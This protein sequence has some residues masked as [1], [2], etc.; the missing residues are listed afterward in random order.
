[1]PTRHL[2]G[3]QILELRLP[4]QQ[5]VFEVQQQ[6]SDWF[7]KQAAPV[8]E[9]LFDRLAPGDEVV[10]LDKL[11]IDLGVIDPQRLFTSAFLEVFEEKMEVT[12]K[13]ALA[14][15]PRMGL[16]QSHFEQWVGFLEKGRMPWFA[17]QANSAK[18]G[19]QDSRLEALKN[20]D[21][22]LDK[23][24]NDLADL[25]LQSGVSPAA[26][27]AQIAQTPN[28]KA[29]WTYG[30]IKFLSKKAKAVITQKR[31][32]AKQKGVQLKTKKPKSLAAISPQ[33]EVLAAGIADLGQQ[34]STKAQ[35]LTFLETGRMPEPEPSS[36]LALHRNVLDTLGLDS[37]AVEQLRNLLLR[38][39]IAFDRL[40]LQHDGLF[41]EKVLVLYTGHDQTGIRQGMEEI[42]AILMKKLPVA[43]SNARQLEVFCWRAVLRRVVLQRHKMEP[44]SLLAYL[45]G[46]PEFAAVLP[47]LLKTA[48]KAKR[49]HPLLASIVSKVAPQKEEEIAVPA[50]PTFPMKQTDEELEAGIFVQNAGIVLLHPFLTTL[51]KKLGLTNE[52]KQFV[53]EE[54]RGRATALLHYLA[55]REAEAPEQDLT[56]P[57]LLSGIPL[58][59]PLDRYIQLTE[60]DMQEAEDLLETAIEMW[61]A[62]GKASPDGLREGFL[63][64]QGK[65]VRRERGWLLQVERNSLDIL[66]GKLPWGLG[67]VKLPWMTEM[68]MVEWG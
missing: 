57:K 63:Q 39:P 38:S 26:L 14:K 33:V 46:L 16:R 65:L 52:E 60:T 28:L 18:L 53:G 34:P 6:A 43:F 55:S 5:V 12:L 51:F 19:S 1:M 7:W 61:G 11:E 27:I 35:W 54:E 50:I 47:Y 3:K 23:W 64:R 13:A 8:L 24:L 30:I 62:L 56:L 58:D 2:I 21:A 17:N 29:T 4:S 59:T 22:S 41:L 15:Q 48:Q 67:I 49:K 68:L 44:D 66:L 20:M 40:V 42:K 25:S 9:R 45:L 32:A 37:S 36:G 10:R 31:K